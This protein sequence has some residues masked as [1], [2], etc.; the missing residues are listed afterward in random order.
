MRKVLFLIHVS[1]DGF[2]AGP[3]GEL[4]WIVYSEELEK[5]VH[6]LT[7]TLDGAIYGRVTFEGM[8][9]YWPTVAGNPEST[10]PEVDYALWLDEAT[11]IVVSTTL[12]KVEWQNTLLIKDNIAAE[13]TR[14]KQQPGQ[15]LILIGSPSLAQT[16]M[17]LGLIDEY[18]ININPV[19]LGSGIPLYK[20]LDSKL[21]LKLLELKKF[22][23]GVVALRYAYAPN[24]SSPTN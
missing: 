13:I 22:E 16:F 6:D 9:S 17:K 21:D 11:K 1:L 18:W 15:D 4:D 20:G 23:G 7:S 5:Y 12:E 24:E 2:V 10:K 8:L 19:V 3:N 14:I